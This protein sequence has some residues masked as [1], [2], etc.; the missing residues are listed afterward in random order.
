MPKDLTVILVNRPGTL[1]DAA[2]ALGRAGV[3]IE[4]M[5][6]FPAAGEGLL[7][8]LVDDVDSARKALEQAG[9]EVRA[10]RDVVLLGPL[11]AQPG[12]LGTALRGIADAGANVDLLYA[13]EDGRVVVSGDDVEAIRQAAGG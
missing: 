11:P 8:V 4:G 1:A 5:C 6:G 7:H 13:T 10:E 2:E 12:T 9:M 3:N